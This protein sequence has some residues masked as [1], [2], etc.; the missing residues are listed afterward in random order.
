MSVIGLFG[1]IDINITNSISIPILGV[2]IFLNGILT[3]KNKKAL[4]IFVFSS[5]IFIFCICIVVFY[6]RLCT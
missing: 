4:G 2:V 5:A 6:T 3:Y 1:I